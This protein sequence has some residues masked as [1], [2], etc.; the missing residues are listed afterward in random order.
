MAREV[1]R[2]GVL[3]EGEAAAVFYASSVGSELGS[4]EEKGMVG[5]ESWC[6]S[7]SDLVKPPG[8]AKRGR[9]SVART[10]VADA[11]F[12]ATSSANQLGQPKRQTGDGLKEAERRGHP[13]PPHLR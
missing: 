13:R 11:G 1:A 10:R 5:H 9:R 3:L 7:L 12:D 4:I 8:P 2:V 6:G